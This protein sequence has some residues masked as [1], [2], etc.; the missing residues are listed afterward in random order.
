MGSLAKPALLLVAA[1]AAYFIFFADSFP[2]EI[3]Y[4]G[5]KFLLPGDLEDEGQTKFMQQQSDSYTLLSSS[6]SSR[7]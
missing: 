1:I 3:E 5:N 6:S 2:N 4:R 7:S